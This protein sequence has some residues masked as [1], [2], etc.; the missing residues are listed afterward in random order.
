MMNANRPI[1]AEVNVPLEFKVVEIDFTVQKQD[2]L[3]I[4]VGSFSKKTSI[5]KQAFLDMY[6]KLN[7]L[8]C[9]IPKKFHWVICYEI[10]KKKLAKEKN[11]ISMFHPRIL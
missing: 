1:E 3:C 7:I 9:S 11:L 4:H 2:P 5:Q 8:C 10:Q 6:I